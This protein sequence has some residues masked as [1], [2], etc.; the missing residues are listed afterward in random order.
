MIPLSLSGPKEITLDQ[1]GQVL[2]SCLMDP[3]SSPGNKLPPVK[4]ETFEVERR[5]ASII[6]LTSKQRVT[7]FEDVYRKLFVEAQRPA[8]FLQEVDSFLA[9][10]MTCC[11][12]LEDNLT[13]VSQR[14]HSLLQRL[15][16]QPLPLVDFPDSLDKD[17]FQ[18]RHCSKGNQTLDPEPIWQSLILC[19]TININVVRIALH[20]ESD[21]LLVFIE[22]VADYLDLLAELIDTACSLGSSDCVENSATWFLVRAAFWSSW[23]RCQLL[24]F[25]GQARNEL[26][27]RSSLYGS[28]TRL[29]TPTP[30]PGLS[31]QEMSRRYASHKKHEYMCSWVFELLRAQKPCMG[32]DFRR[33]HACFSGFWKGQQGRCNIDAG[34]SCSIAHS[35]ACQGFTGL[36]IVDQSAHDAQCHSPCQRLIWDR[37]SFISIKGS[38]AVSLKQTH[39]NGPLRY[40]AASDRTLAISHV[41]SHGQGGR[42]EDGINRCLHLRYCEIARELGCD[43]YWW[44]A[45]CIPKEH[46]LRR[47]AIMNINQT[48]ADSKV[49]L[50][51]D[52]D[53]M[54][55]D[56]SD[57]G[58]QTK[59]AIFTTFLVCDWNIRAWTYLESVRGRGR[60]HILCKDNKAISFQDIVKD[61][62]H[63]GAVELGILCLTVPHATMPQFRPAENMD[64]EPAGSVL[65]HRPASRPGDDVVIW[66]LLISNKLL[67]TAKD[68]W[69]NQKYVNTEF[70]LS[71][72]P[73]LTLRGLSWAPASPYC[74]P[75]G[76]LDV[77]ESDW[78]S[79]RG[80]E[81]YA[82]DLA[83]VT[84]QGLIGEWMM[85]KFYVPEVGSSGVGEASF[86]DCI[87]PEC[88][89]ALRRISRLY[90][91]GYSRGALI[92][93]AYGGE[94]LGM[95][96]HRGSMFAILGARDKRSILKERGNWKRWK[97]KGIFEWDRT[98]PRPLFELVRD[99]L[100]V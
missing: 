79:H 13:N 85:Y 92:Q 2:L 60:S 40:C 48:F 34:K 58:I 24:Y 75:G 50:V 69:R 84:T 11:F 18:A 21:P 89:S 66:S 28:Q 82:G 19:N 83:R 32:M 38:M 72:A 16:L 99:V 44:D 51:C 41:W 12:V 35:G 53:L 76:Q 86:G 88:A 47:E 78:F 63:N 1:V 36:T 15:P 39:T 22:P 20:V 71:S 42:P 52:R 95:V 27:R 6:H 17:Y 7:R 70:L 100:I 49:T 62:V 46:K 67:T 59:Q 33:L 10:L 31:L 77:G 65:S 61:I 29:L 3:T 90:L 73:R 23:Q 9:S 96:R 91:G 26:C 14:A 74:P 87:E 81:S 55:I 30:T 68:F 45:P 5:G 54:M 25:W 98:V 94:R 97:W 93:P 37:A 57:V 64:V 43:S 56:A 4:F 8:S 80:S